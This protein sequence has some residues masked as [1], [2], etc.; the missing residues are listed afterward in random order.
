M[1]TVPLAYAGEF[2]LV[3]AA[4]TS[5]L[6]TCLAMSLAETLMAWRGVRTER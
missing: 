3:P 1:P 4:A 5:L 2:L 6:F